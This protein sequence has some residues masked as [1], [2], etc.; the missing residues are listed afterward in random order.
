VQGSLVD[1][2]LIILVL[3]FAVNGY[4]QGFF[5]GLLSFIGF[6]GGAAI[7]LQLGP[8]LANYFQADLARV[9]IS[10]VTVF[11]IAL[12]GQAAAGWIGARIRASIHNRTGQT[13]DD[14]GGALVSVI[15]VLL[16]AW[17]VATPLGSSSLP[18]LARAVKSSSVLHG[19]NQVMP[20]QAR[21]LSDAL[22]QTLNTNGFPNVFGELDP[23]KVRQVPTP[24][25]TLAGSGVVARSQRSVVKVLGSA[26]S[27]S[28]RIEGSGFV[29]ARDHVL[30]NAHVVAG[31]RTI[32]IDQQG[33]RR[34]GRVVQYDP[35]RDLAV[36]YVPGLSAPV[37]SFASGRAHSGDDAIVLGYPLD[38]PYNAQSARVRDAGP[39]RGPDIYDANTVT[40]DIYTIRGLVR[41][42]NSGGPL[43]STNGLVLGVIFAAAADDRET[44]FAL[45]AAEAAPVAAAGRDATQPVDTGACAQG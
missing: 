15:A 13:I 30:T 23:T 7:G 8:W 17:L 45:T 43:V 29:Y 44:G 21:V 19:I 33:S 41:S 18:A 31:T 40:R 24:D 2:V 3:V 12:A 38:G 39:I 34:P 10:L 16:V 27:C 1:I 37:M 25:P 42:G 4:R 20:S 22:R 32:S 36:I 35:E 11:A 5:I 9:F 26:P 28:R 14:L 6:F